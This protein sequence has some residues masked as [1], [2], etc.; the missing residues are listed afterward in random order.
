MNPTSPSRRLRVHLSPE[1]YEQLERLAEY[2]FHPVP[3]EARLLLEF[4]INLAVERWNQLLTA[5]ER[6]AK[7]YPTPI[8]VGGVL[9]N[10]LPLDPAELQS[11]VE[12]LHR[13]GPGYDE[14]DT[15]PPL[16][17]PTRFAKG[18]E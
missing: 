12:E 13:Q 5:D 14:R 1:R 15:D 3:L 16:S 10:Q 6:D 8:V 18:E 17:D 7:R 11:A 9:Y 4:A 2:A